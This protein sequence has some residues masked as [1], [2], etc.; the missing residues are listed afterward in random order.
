MEKGAF[1]P[2]T[3][4]LTGMLLRGFPQSGPAIL[5]PNGL[6]IIVKDLV[7]MVIKMKVYSTL[8]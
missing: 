8:S 6:S 1:L 5:G 7:L 4:Y 3:R 2:L